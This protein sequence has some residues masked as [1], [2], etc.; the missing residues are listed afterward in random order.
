MVIWLLGVRRLE[1]AEVGMEERNR[2]G[3]VMGGWWEGGGRDG[4]PWK[5]TH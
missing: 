2:G 4:T 3:R 1:A 5:R